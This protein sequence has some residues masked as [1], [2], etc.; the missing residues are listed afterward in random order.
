MIK[1]GICDDQEIMQKKLKEILCDC[2]VELKIEAEIFIYLS[3]KDVL[4]NSMKLDLLFLD[5]E[6]PEMD[7]IETGLALKKQGF[8]G[9][10]IMASSAVERFK[11]AFTIQAFRFVTKPFEKSEILKVLKAYMDEEDKGL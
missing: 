1:I 6:M 3:G 11:E 7:G 5:I 9:K 4:S 10:I 2:L 8:V